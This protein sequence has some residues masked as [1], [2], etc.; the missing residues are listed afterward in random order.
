MLFDSKQDMKEQIQKL[1][2]SCIKDNFGRINDYSSMREFV[3]ILH[4]IF[5]MVCQITGTFVQFSITDV[6]CN[7]VLSTWNKFLSFTSECGEYS[8]DDELQPV[9]QAKHYSL[10]II[11]LRIS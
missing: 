10:E 3:M 6:K 8:D 9:H 4:I 5:V 7:I 1:M 2:I 11:N